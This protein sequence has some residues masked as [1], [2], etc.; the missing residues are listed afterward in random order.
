MIRNHSGDKVGGVFMKLEH[1]S[2]EMVEALAACA[3]CELVV[4]FSLSPMV[5]EVD[6]LL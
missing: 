2:P 4:S 3:A 6:S 5:F 1:V